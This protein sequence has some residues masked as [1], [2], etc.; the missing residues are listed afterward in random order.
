M[1][2]SQIPS[3]WT[4]TRSDERIVVQHVSGS[5]YAA[6]KEGDSGIAE[7]ILY[8]LADSLL[9][10]ALSPA[11]IEDGEEVE[12]VG[13]LI[14]GEQG[15]DNA[16]ELNP[17]PVMALADA[18]PKSA[19]PLM[20]VAQHQRIVAARSSKAAD[21]VEDEREACERWIRQQIG[22]PSHIAMDWEAPL[23]RYAWLAWKARAALCPAYIEDGEEVEVVERY[24]ALLGGLKGLAW[25]RLQ[26][27]SLHP[28]VHAEI[29]EL[30]TV[31]Q[32]QR[33]VAA[34]RSERAALMDTFVALCDYLGI[35][36][37]QARKLP[38]K[39][40]EVF[41]AAIEARAALSA[42]PAAGVPD[43]WKLIPAQPN[44]AMLN[45][46][47][48]ISGKEERLPYWWY[49][50]LIKSAP[51]PPASEQQRA[52]VM[53]ERLTFNPDDMAGFNEIWVNARNATLDEF[54]RLNPH[55]AKGEGV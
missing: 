15:W 12:V 43:G 47:S 37:Q 2:I 41:I 19:M 11:H 21:S 17:G 4:I 36:P 13:T 49:Q 39:P 44:E 45:Q 5:F 25:E 53:P 10:A 1:S 28:S 16:I 9:S 55:L 7:S 50:A 30:M 32:H 35:D 18:H 14:I 52:V 23:A 40:S 26:E 24:R 42:P 54:L 34:H 22:M 48:P 8:M 31:A 20:T 3:G 27:F 38:G 6:A 33:I 29:V 51:T 46:V